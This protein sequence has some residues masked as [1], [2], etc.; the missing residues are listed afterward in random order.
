MKLDVE[1]RRLR[2]KIGDGP[3]RVREANSR[4]ATERGR[5]ADRSA[6]VRSPIEIRH[7]RC[8]GSGSSARAAAAGS[9]GIPGIANGPEHVV[10]AL[11]RKRHVAQVRFANEHRAGFLE[12]QK[13]FARVCGNAIAMT[14]RAAGGFDSSGV[15]RVFQRI[16]DARNRRVFSPIFVF[17]GRSQNFQNRAHRVI[18]LA[19][20]RFAL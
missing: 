3:R 8:N 7:A 9:R 4:D 2:K 6:E 11:E 1:H 10:V 13:Y 16:R 19:N 14:P 12:R 15:P 5:H 18:A 17:C 20:R